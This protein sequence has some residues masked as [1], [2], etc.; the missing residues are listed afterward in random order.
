MSVG[1][2]VRFNGEKGREQPRVFP[3]KSRVNLNNLLKRAKEQEKK[4]K[5]NSLTFSA[6]ALSVAAV[7]GVI[8]TL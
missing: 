3:E 8:L 7:F 4:T 5:R 6:V 1:E 2:S